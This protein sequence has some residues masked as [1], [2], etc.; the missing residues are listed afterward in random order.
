MTEKKL[1]QT[2]ATWQTRLGLAVWTIDVEYDKPAANGTDALI[3]RSHTY[4]RATLRLHKAWKDWPD[5][6]TER[7]LVH[8]LL[9]L[10]T[11][12]V[13]R[14][15]ASAQKSLHPDAWRL[16]NDRYDHEIEG[17]IDRLAVHLVDYANEE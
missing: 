5:R 17:F 10:S 6:K 9:H 1:E 2:L 14:V 11:R 13:D 8:E 12:D 4:D 3:D 7:I 16:L 15:V